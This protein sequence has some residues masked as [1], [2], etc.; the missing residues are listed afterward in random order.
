MPEDH[1]EK[2]HPRAA[3]ASYQEGHPTFP[4]F[5]QIKK[6]LSIDIFFES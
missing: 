5:L 1:V 3:R 2:D 4:K 6:N